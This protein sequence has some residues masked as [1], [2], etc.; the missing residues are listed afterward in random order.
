MLTTLSGAVSGRAD[1]R[2]EAVTNGFEASLRNDP[3]Y[4]F[5]AVAY[6]DGECV[7]DVWGGPHLD[8]DSVMVPFSVTKNIIGF[9]I[10]LLVERGELDLDKRVAA[11]W[12]EFG[13]FGKQQVTARM[14]LSHQAGLP[15]ASPPAYLG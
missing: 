9:S 7:L 15:Q 5:Q 13:E 1:D 14:L 3:D 8:G 12:P 2:L 6:H 4:S 10:A 11:Y